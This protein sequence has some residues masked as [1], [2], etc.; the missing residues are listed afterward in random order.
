VGHKRRS[1]LEPNLFALRC[2]E[3]GE[4]LVGTESG[5][6]ACPRWHGKL[7]RD[8]ACVVADEAETLFGRQDH[9]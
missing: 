2:E 3:C 9:G 8:E 5:F 6:L 4:Q 1:E 7:V